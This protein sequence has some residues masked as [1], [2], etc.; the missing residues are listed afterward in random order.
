MKD[1]RATRVDDPP[2]GRKV[3]CPECGKA[4]YLD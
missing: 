4:F 3:T 2:T 1:G